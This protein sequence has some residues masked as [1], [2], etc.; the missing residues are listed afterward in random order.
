MKQLLTD[1]ITS[2]DSNLPY[3]I[4]DGSLFIKLSDKYTLKLCI[5]ASYPMSP[6]T[7]DCLR[8][9][10]KVIQTGNSS[11]EGDIYFRRLDN[12]VYEEGNF[13]DAG[14]YKPYEKDAHVKTGNIEEILPNTIVELKELVNFYRN[15]L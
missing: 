12:V 3:V 5:R 1:L 9:I 2:I 15:N 13:Y 11:N 7:G 10:I 4:I 6:F 14:E 8:Y